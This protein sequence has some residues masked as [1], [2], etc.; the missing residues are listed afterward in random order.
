[1][2]KLLVFVSV[3]LLTIGCNKS[4][5]SNPQTKNEELAND[6]F[7]RA[8]EYFNQQDYETAVSLLDSALLSQPDHVS[9][10]ATRASAL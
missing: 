7:A 9:S 8:K 5:Q 10:I 6:Y 2:K 3:I 4:E 1:M